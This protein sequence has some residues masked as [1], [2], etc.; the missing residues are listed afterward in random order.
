MGSRKL[1]DISYFKTGG[2]C[3]GIL[4]PNTRE[5]LQS[6]VNDILR[7]GSPFFVL[8]RGSNSLIL[9]QDFHGFVILLK[10]FDDIVL[11]Q[12][13]VRVGAGVENTDLAKFARDNELEGVSWMNRLPGEVGGTV[14]MN[15][16]CYGGEISHVVTCVRAVSK[17]GSIVEHSGGEVFRGYKDTLFMTNGDIIFEVELRLRPGN[18]AKIQH[19]MNHCENDRK[20]KGQF[21]FPSCGCV[22]KNNYNIGVPS[23]MLLELAGAKD[24][25]VNG[26]FVSPYHAN[27][28][29]NKGGSADDILELSRLMREAVYLEFGV[30]LEFEMEV[31]GSPNAQQKAILEESR[32]SEPNEKL[33]KVRDDFA[34]KNSRH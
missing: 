30:W 9:D 13:G 10:N 29:F 11:S 2:T 20:A 24:F 23:G 34:A 5:E 22:F 25:S 32:W 8:G 7:K 18:K 27:F 15:A 28:I 21:D 31:L 1:S 16:R 4:E 3:L 26:A 33:V 19:H 6:H 14:R 12:D 17:A